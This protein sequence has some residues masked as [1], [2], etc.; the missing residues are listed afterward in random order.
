MIPPNNLLRYQSAVSRARL[1]L[2]YQLDMSRRALSGS[3]DVGML[4]TDTWGTQ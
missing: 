4:A 3:L 1:I 2:A